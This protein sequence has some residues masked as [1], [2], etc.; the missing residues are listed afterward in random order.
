MAEVF[1]ALI[2]GYGQQLDTLDE[3]EGV[4]ARVELLRQGL[5][6]TRLGLFTDDAEQVLSEQ[7]AEASRQLWT[8]QGG[9]GLT[10]IAQDVQG[11]RFYLLAGSES[12]LTL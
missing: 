1:T 2:N 3:V 9:V 4:Q 6:W 10:L 8:R 5:L 7:L 11:V 12:A